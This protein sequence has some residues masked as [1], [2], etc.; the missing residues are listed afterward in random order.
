MFGI[1]DDSKA[2]RKESAGSNAVSEAWV[3]MRSHRGQLIHTDLLPLK[4]YSH[5]Q[6]G[7]TRLQIK[8]LLHHVVKSHSLCKF[9]LL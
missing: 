2:A 7:R 1:A 9:D 5:H 4:V 3:M 6:R 8:T